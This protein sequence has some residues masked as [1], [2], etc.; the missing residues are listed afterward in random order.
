LAFTQ[1][2]TFNPQPLHAATFTTISEADSSFD[3]QDTLELRTAKCECRT[4]MVFSEFDTRNS[5]FGVSPGSLLLT[6][7]AALTHSPCTATNTHKL[8]LVVTNEIVVSTNSRIDVSGQALLRALPRGLDCIHVPVAML[9]LNSVMKR[10]SRNDDIR[11]RHG[12]AGVPAPSCQ[13]QR[14]EPDRRA[15]WQHWQNLL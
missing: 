14:G 8:D 15:D 5:S 9:Q 3:G 4:K 6:N 7:G 11:R 12:H 10:T 13:T 1:L 2:S